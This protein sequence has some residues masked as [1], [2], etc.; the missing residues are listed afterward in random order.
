MAS[1][2]Y[3]LR[4]TGVSYG[5][6]RALVDVNLTF[7]QGRF[8]GIIGPNG[9]GKTTLINVLMGCNQQA[10]V[11]G[12]VQFNGKSIAS[13]KKNIL[14]RQLAIVPQEIT[15]GFEF[16][17]YEVVLMGR[18]PYIPRFASP[19]ADDHRIVEQN[20]KLLDL[21]QYRNQPASHLS[22]GEK[23]RVLIARALTQKTAVLL[24]DEATSSL[25]IHH[26]I[27]VM[28]LLQQIVQRHGIT[29]IASIHDLNLAGA[30]CTDLI[31][32]KSGQ[33]HA[34]GA[35]SSI[36]TDDFVSLI[37]NVNAQVR[38]NNNQG[39]QVHFKYHDNTILR[40]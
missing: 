15:L 6:K 36:L 18:N 5:K 37:F 23:Q 20:L 12:D 9:S 11:D 31:A 2:I 29:V 3:S 21:W 33:V 13:Y 14:A 28:A 1:T 35:A 10:T 8:Y 16:T 4:N 24:L 40:L 32:L 22:G 7:E 39:V 38:S 17:V 34:A 27:S 30:F 26:A 25:D 19:T